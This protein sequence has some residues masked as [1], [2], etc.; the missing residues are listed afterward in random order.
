MLSL[1]T[2]GDPYSYR[3]TFPQSDNSATEEDMR[4][5][6]ECLEDGDISVPVSNYNSK[7]SSTKEVTY[8]HGAEH[9]FDVE[10]GWGAYLETVATDVKVKVQAGANVGAG[11]CKFHSSSVKRSGTGANYYNETYPYNNYDF[12]WDFG[13]WDVRAYKDEDDSA[14]D[15]KYISVLG[16]T[17]NE[18]T[19]PTVA[20]KDFILSSADGNTATFS[21]ELPKVT[22][23]RANA[24][25]YILR[26]TNTQTGNTTNIPIMLS[27]VEQQ[28][29]GRYYY[30]LSCAELDNRTDYECTLSCVSSGTNWESVPSNEVKFRTENPLS[31]NIAHGT[32]LELLEGGKESQKTQY[33]INTVYYRIKDGYEIPEGY[34][35]E[36]KNGISVLVN[37]DI[38]SILGSPI[39]DTDITIPDMKLKTYNISYNLEGGSFTNQTV[40]DTYQLLNA[41]IT[42]PTPIQ[43]G[44]EFA[45]WT[46]EAGNT[47]SAI[48]A[49]T[50]GDRTFTATWTPS[51]N[52]AYTVN[53]YFMDTNGR[54]STPESEVLYGT[55]GE[56][57][58]PQPRETEGF[59]HPRV[60][61]V[62]IANDGSTV[63]SYEYPREKYNLDF[64][65]SKTAS[66]YATRGSY[67]FAYL[68]PMEVEIEDGYYFTGWSTDRKN[69]LERYAD[70]PAID[71]EIPAKNV[72]VYPLTSLCQEF[73]EITL[74][75]E[76]K[77]WDGEPV[78]PDV[79]IAD[80]NQ[81]DYTVT[82]EYYSGETKLSDAPKATGTYTVKAIITAKGYN[83]KEVTKEFTISPK[84]E[85]AV[86]Q[87]NKTDTGYTVTA[88]RKCLSSEN[89][90]IT[91][92][93]TAVYM[94]QQ[95][96]DF[97]N[98]G[99][100]V[101]TAVFEN[102][103]FE[104]Q[105]KETVIP[106][107]EVEYT[108]VEASNATCTSNGNI[109][110]YQG[111]NGKVYLSD[112]NGG[113]TE[114]TKEAVTLAR[115]GHSA[116]SYTTGRVAPTYDSDGYYYR[117][118]YCT[119]C[120]TTLSSTRV[121]LSKLNRTD[122]S[123]ASLSLSQ[124]E[125]DYTGKEISP[126]F[127]VTLNGT[128]LTQDTDYVVSGSTAKDSGTYTLTITGT[129]A[130][131]GTVSAEWTIK[132]QPVET[133]EY[134][135]TVKNG[136][137]NGKTSGT[138]K[139]GTVIAVKAD[140]AQDG[141][142]FGYWKKNGKTAS[143]NSVYTFPVTSDQIQLEA[144]YLEDTD[145]AGCSFI[146]ILHR[147]LIY[148][149]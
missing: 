2:P 72:T 41:D 103:A 5:A 44:Y 28:S 131:E 12:K 53:H 136:T 147:Q 64:K 30:S 19:S 42:L 95:E 117:V 120:G 141:Y 35:G 52:V 100:G 48:S 93:V 94:V 63:V 79:E 106:V 20:P 27:N 130:Y 55:T 148:Y 140:A 33:S 38:I 101:Y 23:G 9:G 49:N 96:P 127:T 114:T 68:V 98:T 57:V 40:K 51:E 31:V 80:M 82:Y 113:Y 97:E 56:T 18:I 45:G 59:G 109:A 4:Y 92:T 86:Y 123:S 126:A 14:N 8:S 105:T 108:L 149:K 10:L 15:S 7:T 69:A 29:D 25:S 47:V 99:V 65:D 46:D 60:Q 133:P 36:S 122:I 91:E 125:F 70:A 32:G 54:Y 104:T 145:N 11:Y 115:T 61:S 87:W 85:D 6:R 39:F 24:A 34:Y 110:Y 111:S 67:Y 66:I 16:Y 118:T 77:E 139:S 74:T 84:Y 37:D 88:S 107:K 124:K 142:K 143:Y 43:A 112:G 144:V 81:D 1:G 116:S 78:T 22:Q 71:F 146:V 132:E 76:D 138:F 73:G 75:A 58:T 83:S 17:V 26:V 102:P 128:E 89:A 129:G 121:T 90:D 3:K 21:W 134:S 135:V 50:T 62:K 119:K 13:F 137:V